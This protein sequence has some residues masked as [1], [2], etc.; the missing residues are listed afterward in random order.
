MAGLY[1]TTI[2]L[3]HIPAVQRHI[4]GMLAGEISERLGTSVKTGRVDLGFI[5]RVI[6]DDLLLFDQQ[7]KHMLEAK[8]LS[9]KID[10]WELSHGRIAISSAQLFGLK[11]R[12]YK[13]SADAR[14]NYQFVLDSLASKDTTSHKPLDVQVG[15]LIIRHGSLAYDEYYVPHTGQLSASHIGIEELSAHLIVNK[16]S[17]D[18][19]NIKAKKLAF[20]EHSG[21]EVRSL[22]FRLTANR[23]QA[24][25]AGLELLMPGSSITVPKAEATYKTDE[26]GKPDPGTLKFKGTWEASP[27]APADFKCLV[28]VLAGCDRSLQMG[29][30]FA[31]SGQQIGISRFVVSDPTGHLRLTA[32]GGIRDDGTGTAHWN[33]RI[34]DLRFSG[35]DIVP[36]YKAFVKDKPV[37]AFLNALGKMEMKGEAS[38]T[39]ADGQLHAR[40]DSE[41]GKLTVD[42][43]KKGKGVSGELKATGIDLQ[44]LLGNN[45]LG[46]LT[47]QLGID[48]QWPMVNV[49]GE[50]TE[51]GFKGYSY[52]GISIDG[53]WKG[54]GLEGT[55][56]I[57]DPNIQLTASGGTS[58]EKGNT[59]IDLLTRIRNMNP[60]QLRLTDKWENT[61]FDAVIEASVKGNEPDHATGTIVLSDFSMTSADTHYRLNR[62]ALTSE[63]ND[64]R[65]RIMLN[66][67]FG[68]AVLDGQYRLASIGRSLNNLVKKKLPTAPGI[69]STPP[70]DNRLVFRATLR[71]AQ[72]LRHIVGIPLELG[73]PLMISGSMDDG[74]QQIDVACDAA[75]LTYGDSR[76]SDA[77]L[78]ITTPNDTLKATAQLKR[79]TEKGQITAWNIKAKAADNRLHTQVVFSN[80]GQHRLNG[81]FSADARFDRNEDNE[82][83][84]HININPS[85]VCVGD[86]VWNIQSSNISYSKDCLTIDHL[87]I[88]HNNQFAQVA[89]KATKRAADELTVNLQDIDISYILNLVN[90]H[91]VEFS[92]MASGKATVASVFGSPTA[93]A[94]LSV[95]GFRFENGR[96]GTL[97]ATA[98]YDNEAGQIDI[99]ATANDEDNRQTLISGYVSP[100]NNYIDLDIRAKDTRLEFLYS[101]CGSFMRDIEAKANGAVKLSGPLNNINLTGELTTTGNIG[102]SSLNTDY[103][104]GN[105]RIRF[106]PDEIQLLNDTIYDRNGNIGIVSG[107]LYHKH[108]TRLSYDLNVRAENLLGYET[109]GFNGDTFYGTAFLTGDCRIKGKSG[110]VTIDV[111]ATPQDGSI[112]VYNVGSPDAISTGEFIRWRSQS[113][114]AEQPAGKDKGNGNASDNGDNDYDMRTNIKLNMLVNC[115]PKATIK[116]LMD[117]HTGDYIDLHGDGVLRATYY[118]KGAFDLFGNYTV[119]DG[120]YK[121]TIQNAIKKDFEFQRGGTISFGGDPYKATL[122]LNAQYTL[123]GVS[124][125]DLNIGRSFSSNNIKVNCLMNI[126]GTPDAPKVDF[127]LDMPTVSADAKQMVYSI[128]NSEEEM[129][130]QVLYL[131][132]VGRFYTQG[133]NNATDGTQQSQT[134]LAMQSLLSGTISQQINTL[135][136]GVVNSNKWN[137]GANIS[138][139]DEGFNNAEYEALLSGKLLNNRLLINGEFGYRDNANTT[140]SF[141][142]DFDLR[143]LLYPNGNL[144]IRVYNQTNDRYFTRNSMNTQGLGLIMK[145]DFGNWRELFGVK[146][147]GKKKKRQKEKA[148]YNK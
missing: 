115:T 34:A 43:G 67:D 68:N 64:G 137:F 39:G 40:M 5:N 73:K 4:G 44:T 27:I 92:G 79:H 19:I 111:D 58:W 101:F 71:D 25:L 77:H 121:L 113:N 95:D 76:F 3:L 41:A 102:I 91:S 90:F 55:I 11:A 69:P 127:G 148:D 129:N 133:S 104:L 114:T 83:V 122:N 17:D 7:G 147:K 136:E 130:Q 37:P 1:F 70:A 78:R 31:G 128:I 145:K 93:E 125:A 82:D 72:W 56:A 143:Y 96:M 12:L 87:G 10:L 62:L 126:T 9:V 51:L 103:R 81:E 22:K 49:K 117:E 112:I 141:I 74:R 98:T 15:S 16:L 38:G 85:V 84:A 106:I 75:Q 48:G 123:N 80:D 146:P 47:A 105:A 33:A 50:V 134:S 138:T 65:H 24:G 35:E 100:K 59:G 60:E 99:D 124:L 6:I 14:P 45:D 140:T 28:P 66:S 89:G 94:N 108:L 26:K 135:L 21:L 97:L 32:D 120:T 110:E 139:G 131:L 63:Q 46:R 109:H 36:W 13:A 18:S 144:A 119:N 54:N 20:T 116:L 61:T 23:S 52:S 107:S 86:T 118:N 132:A 53:K 42:M 57:D 29:C 2:I 8:R 30:T 142:G 88:R